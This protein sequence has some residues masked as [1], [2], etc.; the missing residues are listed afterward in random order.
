MDIKIDIDGKRVTATLDGALVGNLAVID[1]AKEAFEDQTEV[2]V[3]GLFPVVAQTSTPLGLLA[4]LSAY[5]P[6]RVVVIQAPNEL[7]DALDALFAGL[8]E[9]YLPQAGHE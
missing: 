2:E 8:R 3:F 7:T 5:R 1:A 9:C 4:G 6:G